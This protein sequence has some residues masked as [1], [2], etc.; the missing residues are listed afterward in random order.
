VSSR[1]YVR[2]RRSRVKGGGETEH[3]M[4]YQKQREWVKRNERVGGR[5]GGR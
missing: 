5:G 2:G 3:D 4:V 1:K